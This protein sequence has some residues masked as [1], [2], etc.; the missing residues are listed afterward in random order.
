MKDDTVPEID[1]AQQ[2]HAREKEEALNDTYD[3]EEQ[4]RDDY[5]TARVIDHQ[6][7]RALCRKF[8]V[9]LMPVLA[10]MCKPPSPMCDSEDITDSHRL[11]QRH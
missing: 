3:Y 2:Q 11:L 7:E 4:T 8:D 10:I 6:A 1:A 9:R 5:E